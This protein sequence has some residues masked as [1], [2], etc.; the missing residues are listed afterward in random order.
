MILPLFAAGYTQFPPKREQPEVMSIVDPVEAEIAREI[1]RIC[2]KLSL[3]PRIVQTIPTNDL[4]ENTCI[5]YDDHHGKEIPSNNAIKIPF[6]ISRAYITCTT[7]GHLAADT[8]QNFPHALR[9]QIQVHLANR[10]AK[11]QARKSK[12][13]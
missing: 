12:T 6:P 7:T 2:I 1:T 8:L 11:I 13:A 5:I 4:D 3:N 10:E 9:A